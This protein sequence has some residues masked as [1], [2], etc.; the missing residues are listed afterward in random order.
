MNELTV[1]DD[2]FKKCF[3]TMVDGIMKAQNIFKSINSFEDIER[4]FLMGS[5]LSH[6][7]YRT[8]LSAVRD[9]YT[10]TEGMNPL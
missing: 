7:T 10:F 4:V 5:G 2:N 6:N 9:F 1:I 3:P 8:Y